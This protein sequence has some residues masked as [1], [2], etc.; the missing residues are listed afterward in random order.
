MKTRNVWRVMTTTTYG[1][2]DVLHSDPP[3]S[4]C[5]NAFR[6]ADLARGQL[7]VIDGRAGAGAIICRMPRLWNGCGLVEGERLLLA[8]IAGSGKAKI[9]ERAAWCCALPIVCGDRDG[10]GRRGR[11]RCR[12]ARGRSSPRRRRA[13]N[14]SHSG[15]RSKSGRWV[16]TTI[17]VVVADSAPDPFPARRS[18]RRRRS[19][20]RARR[21][22]ARR[23]AR[24]DDRTS[25]ASRRSSRGRACRR[26]ARRRA[27]RGRGSAS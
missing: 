15:L 10:C 11:S 25:S 8:S 22:R 9:S 21:C 6:A 17:G 7:D 12:T 14:H 24:R 5:C 27:R 18:A 19:A 16:K 26:R 4:I 1:D 23:S 13:V 20:S 3:L 2:H